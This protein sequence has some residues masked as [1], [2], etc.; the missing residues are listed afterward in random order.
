VACY[1]CLIEYF[2]PDPFGSRNAKIC[3]QTVR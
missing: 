3:L 1:V 2:S